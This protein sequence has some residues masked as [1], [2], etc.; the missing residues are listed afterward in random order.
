MDYRWLVV[1]GLVL[2]I[3]GAICLSYGLILS[4]RDALE[5][6]A[7]RLMAD[8]DEKNM[9]L[10]QVVDRLKQSR[11]AAVGLVFLVA[12]F[13]LQIVGSWPR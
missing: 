7:T 12:G 1:V 13:A 5:L 8:D 3:V 2:D 9:K 4:K 6:G 10:P 11:N